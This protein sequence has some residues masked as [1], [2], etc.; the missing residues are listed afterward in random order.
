MEER[1]ISQLHA[2]LIFLRSFLPHAS[3][4]YIADPVRLRPRPDRASFLRGAHIVFFSEDQVRLQTE[5]RCSLPVGKSLLYSPS[6]FDSNAGWHQ[7]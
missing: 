3:D 4:P 6:V 5:C 1:E 2:I 7:S